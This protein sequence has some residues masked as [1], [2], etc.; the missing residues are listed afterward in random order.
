ML[1]TKISRQI[2]FF[3]RID[4]AFYQFVANVTHLKKNSDNVEHT[5]VKS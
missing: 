2:E 5:F 3:R 1:D 4:T